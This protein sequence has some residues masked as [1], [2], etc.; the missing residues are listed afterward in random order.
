MAAITYAVLLL[1]NVI[2]ANASKSALA[3]ALKRSEKW[4][5]AADIIL[6]MVR[7]Q[8]RNEHWATRRHLPPT[9]MFAE[10]DHSGRKSITRLGQSL[11]STPGHVV[12]SGHHVNGH[13]VAQVPQLER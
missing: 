13:L 5:K 4:S 2:F 10:L 8:E 6:D 7:Y 11:D 9:H 12:L 1:M 3:P